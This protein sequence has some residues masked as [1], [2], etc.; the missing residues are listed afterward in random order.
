MLS[1]ICTIAL[2]INVF[3]I[4][5]DV[6]KFYSATTHTVSARYLFQG[7]DEADRLASGLY[8]ALF[9]ELLALVIFMIHPQH[10]NLRLLFRRLRRHRLE[11]QVMGLIVPGFVP[12]PLGNVVDYS[13][14]LI[15]LLVSLGKCSRLPRSDVRDPVQACTLRRD[16]DPS[17]LLR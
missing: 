6:F 10:K 17:V 11:R 12:T 2:R 8:T 3:M 9:L 16:R 14:T 15:E 7:L 13:P 1:V 4:G 5:T